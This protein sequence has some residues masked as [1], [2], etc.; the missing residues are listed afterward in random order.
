MV[1]FAGYELPVRF[2]AGVLSEHLHTR[3]AASLFDVSHMGQVAL[4]GNDSA[5]ALETLVPGDICGLAPGRMRYTMLTGEGGGILDDLI[6]TNVGKYLFVVVN[7]ARKEADIALLR[8]AG[9]MRVEP[10]EDR[11]L[12]ALQGPAAPGVMARLVPQAASMPFMSA[13][14]AE[15]EGSRLAIM[16][17]GYTGEDGYEISVPSGDAARIAELLLAE[18]EVDPAGLGARDSLRLEAGFCL[19]GH[20]IDESTTPVEAGLA[21][22]IARRRREEGG[23]PGADAILAQMRG[24]P[25]RRRVGLVPDGRAPAREGTEIFDTEDRALGRVTSGGFGPSVGG[26]VAMGYVDAKASA[27]GTPVRLLVRGKPRPA[28]V[29]PMPFVPHRYY[30]TGR[31]K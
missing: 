17:S 6:V 30:R 2:P 24:S 19:Y 8:A 9:G 28:R 20:D 10:L 15:I 3:A 7:A 26:P 13:L 31:E 14:P 27:P 18:D 25:S 12:I 4:L 23:F 29:R 11:S 22:T 21:W 5:A 16:R 1:P